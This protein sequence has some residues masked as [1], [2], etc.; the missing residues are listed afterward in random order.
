MNKRDNVKKILSRYDRN[1]ILL[2]NNIA[3]I[4]RDTR[5]KIKRTEIKNDIKYMIEKVIMDETI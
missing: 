3:K 1:T 2:Y 4:E 5:H